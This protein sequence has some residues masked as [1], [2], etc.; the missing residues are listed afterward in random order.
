MSEGA[1]RLL[2]AEEYGVAL[3]DILRSLQG[4]KH[5]VTGERVEAA[6]GGR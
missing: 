1:V 3:K 5:A 4:P 6:Q 2:A